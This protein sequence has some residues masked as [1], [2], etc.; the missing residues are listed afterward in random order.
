M[1]LMAKIGRLVLVSAALATCILACHS[2][3]S[4]ADP[5]SYDFGGAI[6]SADPS[7]GLAV[8]SRFD[9]TFTFDPSAPVTVH[10]ASTEGQVGYGMFTNSE[11]TLSAGGQHLFNSTSLGMQVGYP[12]QIP[13]PEVP[14]QEFTTVNILG[15]TN[16]LGLTLTL[17]NP[18]RVVF[19]PFPMPTSFSLS[20]FPQA[21]LTL[22]DR[23]SGQG[24]TLLNGTIDTLIPVLAPEPSSLALIVVMLA[25]LALRNARAG[26]NILSRL[27]AAI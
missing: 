26:K 11:F 5:I 13:S 21:Q 2:A 9:G 6:T 7:T 22:V 23:A 16:Q 8:G 14:L 17:N 27:R 1:R 3:A 19:L 24:E 18:S 10:L 20:D 12:T 4:R 15:M 25:G